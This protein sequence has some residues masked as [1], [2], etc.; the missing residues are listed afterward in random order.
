MERINWDDIRVFL[1]L[2]R[3]KNIREAA[4]RSGVSYS[5][6]SRRVDAFEQRLSARL[7]D[8]L[9][10]GFALTASGEDLLQLAEEIEERVIEADRRTFGQEEALVGSIRLS[11]VDAVATHLV[12]P[13]LAEFTALHPLIELDLDISYDAADLAR[14]ET[15]LALRFAQ[16]P[17]ETLIGRKLAGCG[18]AAYA[19]GDYIQQHNLTGE[20]TGGNWIG[21]RAGP[22]RPDWVRNSA[23]PTLPVRGKIQ[24]LMLQKD[25]C[26][27]GMGVAMLPCFLADP[28]AGLKRVGAVNFSPRFD[29]WLLKHADVRTNARVRVLSDFLAEKIKG[30]RCDLRGEAGQVLA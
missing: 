6:I 12:M 2:A 26:L 8:R 5:T 29:L 1:N 7:F 9:P 3:S 18:T 11:M 27:A 21:F 25:A 19:T 14:R 24:S 23:L 28:V 15:D 17:P 4:A 30:R 16:N 10:S 13:F 20:P 22:T